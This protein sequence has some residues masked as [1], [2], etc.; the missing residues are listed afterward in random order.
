MSTSNKSIPADVSP[1]NESHLSNIPAVN[2]ATTLTAKN[3]GTPLQVPVLLTVPTTSISACNT[4]MMSPTVDTTTHTEESEDISL[5]E[6]TTPKSSH[7]TILTS[8]VSEIKLRE[9]RI[10]L[11]RIRSGECLASNKDGNDIISPVT[12]RKRSVVK[13]IDMFK[14]HWNSENKEEVSS[15]K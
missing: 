11:R 5:P 13:Y 3:N 4:S 10:P 14:C 2:D 9:F 15:S 1:F 12:G 6:R 8:P 7:R